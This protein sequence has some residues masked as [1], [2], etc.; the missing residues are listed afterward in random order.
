MLK[1]ESRWMVETKVVQFIQNEGMRVENSALD[2]H[3]SDCLVAILR[4]EGV[5]ALKLC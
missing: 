2:L 3:S 5:N 4:S 1:E